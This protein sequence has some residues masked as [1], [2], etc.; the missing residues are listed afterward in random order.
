MEQN[1]LRVTTLAHAPGF[2]AV[3]SEAELRIA[4]PATV[5]CE[6]LDSG[7]GFLALTAFRPAAS[8]QENVEAFLAVPRRLR[9][10][11]GRRSPGYWLIAH[12][13][14][15]ADRRCHASSSGPEG[16]VTSGAEYL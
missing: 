8:V 3:R 15:V 12:W 4:G 11:L 1:G 9:A 7:C 6:L 14:D 16:H 5:V 13:R 2:V 10:L